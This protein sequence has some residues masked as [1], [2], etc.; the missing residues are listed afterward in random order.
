MRVD[1][2]DKQGKKSFDIFYSDFTLISK[3]WVIFLCQCWLGVDG[4]SV[5]INRKG[6][7]ERYFGNSKMNIYYE[8]DLFCDLIYGLNFIVM[9]NVLN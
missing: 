1:Q 7:G 3:Y 9:L 8:I 6:G 5:L 4:V 2:K